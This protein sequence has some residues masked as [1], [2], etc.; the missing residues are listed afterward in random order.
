MKKFLALG[1]IFAFVLGIFVWKSGL[2]EDYGEYLITFAE[3]GEISNDLKMEIFVSKFDKHY[4]EFKTEQIGNDYSS[5]DSVLTSDLENEMQD[6]VKFSLTFPKIEGKRKTIKLI[7]NDGLLFQIK[8]DFDKITQ[9]S[10]V[11][12]VEFEGND[13]MILEYFVFAGK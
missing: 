3:N 10:Y 5:I 9:S 4:S 2:E 1:L 13:K 6:G 8:G 7:Y 11:S 12:H